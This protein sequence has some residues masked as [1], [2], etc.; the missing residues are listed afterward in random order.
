MMI[1]AGQEEMK[2][3]INS[4]QSAQTE[5]EELSANE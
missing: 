3:M 1:S 2:A 5:F 4:I